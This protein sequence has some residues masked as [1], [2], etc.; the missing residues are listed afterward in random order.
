MAEHAAD[1][2]WRGEGENAEV[3]LYAPDSTVAGRA[4]EQTLPAARLPGVVTPVYAASS[5]LVGVAACFG[6]VAASETHAV[7]N[8]ISAPEWGLLLVADAPTEGIGA[9][10]EVPRLISRKL[11]EVALPNIGE[12]GV[13]RVTESGALWAAEEGLIEE[14][15][16]PLFAQ[17][18][19]D[20]DALGQRSLAAGTRDWTRPG[21][22]HGM[23]VAEILNA[24]GAEE[25]GLD[26]GA[27]AFV[28]SAEA[29]DLGRLALVGH[30]ERIFAR[31]TSGDF[32]APVDLPMAPVDAEEAKDLLAAMGAAANYAA[33]RA[34]L[35]LYALRRALRDAGTL[36]LRA[37]WTV[38]GFGERD[39]WVLHR[40][41]LVAVGTEEVLVAERTV[42][43]G[44]GEMLG[45]APPFDVAEEDGRWPWE[46]AG[47]LARWAILEPLGNGTST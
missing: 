36:R 42:A 29:E 37:A 39:G 30:R 34:A 14:E 47:I 23:R 13:R 44:T 4:F 25:L 7:P 3:V 1:F 21:E 2:E 11:S 9:P 15:D 45:S 22:M 20:A 8:L 10:E 41:N 24:E 26:P 16:L 18:A 31:A 38:G 33:G 5:R 19:G 6:W 27:L 28:V 12:A 40:N 46:E 35:V 17:R 43:A 32:G